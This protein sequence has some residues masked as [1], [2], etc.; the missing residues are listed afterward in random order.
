MKKEIVTKMFYALATIFYLMYL[1][2]E[3][4]QFMFFGGLFLIVASIM[5][6]ITKKD[7]K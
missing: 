3:K 4:S 5:H 6:V 2:T 1:L 7:K